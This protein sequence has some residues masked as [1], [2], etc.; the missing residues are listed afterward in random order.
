[1]WDDGGSHALPFG[2][3]FCDARQNNA[4]RRRHIP[5]M[6]FKLQNWPEYEVGLHRYGSLTGWFEDAV[7]DNWQALGAW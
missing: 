2:L 6:L 1:M 5:K 4:D 3:F 7:S